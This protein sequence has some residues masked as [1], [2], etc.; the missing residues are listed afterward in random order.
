MIVKY[1]GNIY[2][3]DQSQIGSTSGKVQQGRIND[4]RTCKKS[5][6]I[7]KD[8]TDNGRIDQVALVDNTNQPAKTTNE[9][10]VEKFFE[11]TEKE[12]EQPVTKSE[13]QQIQ[14]E[15]QEL[16]S[17]LQK[18]RDQTLDMFRKQDSMLQNH[19]KR[20]TKSEDK[21]NGVL[22]LPGVVEMRK[23]TCTS[24]PIHHH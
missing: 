19:E 6:L 7:E 21:L 23:N 12:G 16:H 10:S 11:E 8:L 5:Y 15:V 18:I 9:I 22:N 3:V 2:K 1:H 4:S 14:R 20:I 24:N 17:V 13:L